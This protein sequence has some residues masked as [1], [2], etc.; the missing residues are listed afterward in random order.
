VSSSEGN[1][2]LRKRGRTVDEEAVSRHSCEK[3]P[4]F[5]GGSGAQE[6][7]REKEKQVA[8]VRNRDEQQQ[9]GGT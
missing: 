4:S 9:Y 8:R 3:G 7:G 5:G 2:N 1:A 6:K